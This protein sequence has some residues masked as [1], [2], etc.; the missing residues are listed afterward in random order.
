MVAITREGGYFVGWED[1][2]ML[3]VE[4]LLPQV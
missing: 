4:I 3:D 2:G 1:A